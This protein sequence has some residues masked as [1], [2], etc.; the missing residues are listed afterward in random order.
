[1]QY[2]TLGIIE[3]MNFAYYY[4]WDITHDNEYSFWFLVIIGGVK[5]KN[6]NQGIKN[7]IL[8][9]IYEYILFFSSYDEIHIY[10]ITELE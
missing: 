4:H 7:N 1:M 2:N 3:I 6:L 10:Y 8:Y 5:A 9:C